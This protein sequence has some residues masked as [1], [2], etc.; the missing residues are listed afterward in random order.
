MTTKRFDCI[1]FKDRAQERILEDT[2][3][4]SPE[5]RREYLRR[6]AED[7]A[8]GEW[9]RRVK[10]GTGTASGPERRAAAVPAGR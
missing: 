1:E 9:W 4:M 3:S 5:E 8:L 7:G 6:R 10:S 2:R